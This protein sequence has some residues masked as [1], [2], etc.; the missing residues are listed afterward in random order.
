MVL[1]ATNPTIARKSD[2]GHIFYEWIWVDL[3]ADNIYPVVADGN[4]SV[5]SNSVSTSPKQ[6]GIHGIH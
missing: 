2:D 3:A 1:W 5:R 4:M 6:I